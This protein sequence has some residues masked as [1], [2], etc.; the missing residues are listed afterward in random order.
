MPPDEQPPELERPRIYER[1]DPRN[2]AAKDDLS[3][4]TAERRLASTM[5]ASRIWMFAAA[6]ALGG[7]ALLAV[8]A[9]GRWGF[10][11]IAHSFRVGD[12]DAAAVRFVALMTFFGIWAVGAQ[13]TNIRLAICLCVAAIVFTLQIA[14]QYFH[15]YEMLPLGLYTLGLGYCV[16]DLR[17]WQ[18]SAA[19]AETL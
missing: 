13:R 6:L 3:L 16:F 19:R 9:Y 11:E 2:A 15:I 5:P 7:Y 4:Q 1:G 12:E 8:I 18:V 10:L 14:L 17:R